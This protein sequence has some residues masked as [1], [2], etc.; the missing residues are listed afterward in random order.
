MD[1]KYNQPTCDACSRG[2]D[3][4]EESGTWCARHSDTGMA[5]LRYAC[6]GCGEPL[7]PDLLDDEGTCARCEDVAREYDDAA[8]S[9]R[10]IGDH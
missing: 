3:F 1:E 5:I 2:A 9:D 6:R 4:L 7:H 8:H 10:A